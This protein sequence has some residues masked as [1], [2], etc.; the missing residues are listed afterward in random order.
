MSS[1]AW[2]QRRTPFS[3]SATYSFPQVEV[4]RVE[5]RDGLLDDLAVA[6]DVHLA[7]Y[8]DQDVVVLAPRLAPAAP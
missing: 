6:D 3:Q 7:I 1:S 2:F 4:E 8:A 5:Q